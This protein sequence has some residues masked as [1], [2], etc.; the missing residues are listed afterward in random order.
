M[1]KSCLGPKQ[2]ADGYAQEESRGLW[3][4]RQLNGEEKSPPMRTALSFFL[5]TIPTA[6]LLLPGCLGVLG[7][8]WREKT[9]VKM[10]WWFFY[11]HQILRFC[12]LLLQPKPEYSPRFCLY[13]RVYR[14]RGS[15][16]FQQG[17]TEDVKAKSILPIHWHFESW[18]YLAICLQRAAHQT[19]QS[20]GQ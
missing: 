1:F 9:M 17:G 16:Q 7:H 8:N 18:C 14:V 10:T 20:A 19:Y 5:P 15:A 2:Q 6:P 4:R 3:P 13:H 12:F 11:I